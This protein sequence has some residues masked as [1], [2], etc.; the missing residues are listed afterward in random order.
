MILQGGKWISWFCGCLS[1]DSCDFCVECLESDDSVIRYDQYH[2]ILKQ[3][4]D[5]C[6]WYHVI[7]K[8]NH[9]LC[10]WYQQALEASCRRRQSIGSMFYGL[11]VDR[12]YCDYV[13]DVTSVW[14]CLGCEG[15]VGFGEVVDDENHDPVR[16]VEKCLCRIMIPIK[17]MILTRFWDVILMLF[18]KNHDSVIFILESCDPA[19]H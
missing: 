19:A 17:I 3:V 6:A 11:Y 8:Q 16:G 15:V 4:F 18:C 9:V 13:D 1:L 10:F 14:L 2:V 12:R 5:G 7:L